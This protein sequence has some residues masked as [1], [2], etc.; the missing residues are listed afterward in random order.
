MTY[1]MGLAHDPDNEDLKDGERRASK[2]YAKQSGPIAD[3]RKEK[4][5]R[6][7]ADPELAA[8]ENDPVLQRLLYESCSNPAGAAAHL[9]N[10]GV[11]AATVQKLVDYGIIR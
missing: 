11:A 6:A 7:R 8:V 4:L 3:E 1:T 10:A 5:A 2:E 9:K